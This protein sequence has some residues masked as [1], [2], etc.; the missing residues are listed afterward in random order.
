MTVVGLRAFTLV[1]TAVRKAAFPALSSPRVTGESQS[2]AG[3]RE[4][5]LSACPEAASCRKEV[6]I[7]N[8]RF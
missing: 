5:L 4:G 8:R 2:G 7:N 3:V 1:G 6:A